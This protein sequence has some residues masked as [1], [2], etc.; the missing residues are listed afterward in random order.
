MEKRRMY[1]VA[2]AVVAA[3]SLSPLAADAYGFGHFGHGGG[4]GLIVLL[5]LVVAVA[6]VA[7]ISVA[8]RGD[9]FR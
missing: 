7:I 5:L 2:A 4:M 9:R 6:V 3:M 8:A 1:Q